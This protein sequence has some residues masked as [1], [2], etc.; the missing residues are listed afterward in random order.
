[1]VAVLW[2]CR[3]ARLFLGGG[4]GVACGPTGVPGAASVPGCSMRPWVAARPRAVRAASLWLGASSRSLARPRRRPRA[5]QPGPPAPPH[6]WGPVCV[7]DSLLTYPEGN[8]LSRL[9]LP[10]QFGDARRLQRCLPCRYR[11]G[12]CTIRSSLAACRRRV[13]VLMMQFPRCVAAGLR[14]EAVWSPK[15][16]PIG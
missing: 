13:G 12:F 7:L 14:F 9:L 5:P 2:R 15:C 8:N 6:L 16:R 11:W 10:I 4:G 1:M 3:C